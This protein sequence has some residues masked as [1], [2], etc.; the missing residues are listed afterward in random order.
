YANS[1]AVPLLLPDTPVVAYWP[2]IA[3]ESMADSKIGRHA[4]RRITDSS[5]VRDPLAALA[6]RKSGYVPGDTDLAWARLTQW[7][8][9]LA[10]SFDQ[11]MSPVHHVTVEGETDNPSVVLL[12]AW[13]GQS[14]G[15]SVETLWSDR[16]GIRSVRLD[17][18]DNPLTIS[19]N[20]DDKTVTV[21]RPGRTD[22]H[23]SLPRRSVSALLAEDLRRLDPDDMYGQV[24]TNL[25]I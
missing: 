23:L 20:D 8:S 21:I 15:C 7:R 16:I 1:V 22:A 10:S 19:R 13:L 18:D 12:G 6:I 2:G 4:Q 3:P 9:V 25:E 5:N 11:P 17:M 24:I 14:F